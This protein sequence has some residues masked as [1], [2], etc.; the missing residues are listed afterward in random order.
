MIAAEKPQKV[1][2]YSNMKPTGDIPAETGRIGLSYWMDCVLRERDYARYDFAPEHIHDLR[3][4]LRRCRSI[5]DGFVA[6]DPHPAW[7]QMIGELKSLF[8][9][10]GSLR[11][12]QVM[13]EWVERLAP[14]GDEAGDTMTR[15]LRGQEARFRENA[16]RALR[17][18]S[19][20]KWTSWKRQLSKRTRNLPNQEMVFRQIALERWSEMRQLHQQALRNRSHASYHRLRIVLKKFRYTIE[21]FLPTLYAVWGS[22]LKKLQDLLG[23]MHDL[24][25]LWHTA[26]SVRA[27][28]TKE[29]QTKWRERIKQ[30]SLLRLGRYR[31]KMMGSASLAL[32]WRSGL[33]DSTEIKIAAM[34]R[35]RAWAFFRDPDFDHSELV[36]KLAQQIFDGLDSA[37]SLGSPSLH[38]ARWNLE[39]AA[40][41]H[42][43]G[44]CLSHKRHHLASYRMIR[45][46]SPLLGC[47][48]EDIQIIAL[49]ARFHRGALP[50]PGQKAFS[51][52]P[53]EQKREIFLLCGILRLANSFD[54]RHQ[55]SIQRL[56]IKRTDGYLQIIAPGYSKNDASAEMIAAARHLLE[57]SCKFPILISQLP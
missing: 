37:A 54:L 4:A 33:P 26:L 15:Y 11:D 1:W 43:V 3:V 27:L 14:A 41:L 19:K 21:N 56:E 50:R 6:V 51:A 13:M 23:E 28:P 25:V 9:Q 57:V 8:R 48:A 42:D 49:I 53:D 17:D 7:K 32:V 29:L 30:E 44:K 24:Q 5:A 39:A 22:D 40:L 16:R 47:G 36:A 46:M 45:K 34:A 20:K 18:F 12:T 52:I 55:R 31:D 35:L 2:I 10:L 38:D